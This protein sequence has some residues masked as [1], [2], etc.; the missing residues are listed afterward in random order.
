MEQLLWLP[1]LGSND[2]QVPDAA[3][4]QEQGEVQL[5]AWGPSEQLSSARG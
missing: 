4:K 1:F 3:V 5:W 2:R